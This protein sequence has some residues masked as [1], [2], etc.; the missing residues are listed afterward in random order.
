MPWQEVSTMSLRKE[1]VMLA[2]QDG[3]N[4]SELCRRFGISRKTGY[5]WL[6]RFDAAGDKGLQDR[7]RRP[8]KSSNR[9]PECVE[10]LALSVRDAH[11]A[12]GGR[13]IK[14]RLIALGHEGLPSV[15]TMTEILRRNGRLDTEESAKH[16]AWQRFEHDAPNRLW[17]MDFKGH[18]AIDDGRC[19][20][21]TVLDDHSR[22]S[23]GLDACANQQGDTVQTK[24]TEAFRR[25][26]LPERMTMDNG[27]PWGSDAEHPYTPLTVWLIRL[28]IGVSHSRP[29]HPQTQGKDERFHRTLD[30]EVLKG[31]VFHDLDQCQRR[32]D[33]WRAV[34]NLERPHEAIGMTVPA[35]RYRPSDRSF[36][37]TLP[38]IE[39]G[40]GDIIRKVQAKGEIHYRGLVFKVGKA[41]RGHPIA[42]RP[43]SEDGKMQVY[44]CQQCIAQIDLRIS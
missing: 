11:P 41:F 29:Y 37:E 19:H 36:P 5:K 6:D 27:S 16:T 15:S 2:S 24:L 18:F 21:L 17:Q 32:F 43:T 8:H 25:Y 39:Y 12:W 33:E 13:K 10:Q 3:A 4:I 31:S 22:Y 30:V 38:M 44:F 9:T 42:L 14:G 35:S 26:G 1:F 23:L 28:G 20:P 34:Y 40:P 7:S